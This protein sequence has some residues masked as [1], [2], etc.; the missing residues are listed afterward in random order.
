MCH[1]NGAYPVKF[2]EIKLN[3]NFWSGKQ[4]FFQ[5]NRAYTQK[6][7]DEYKV[8]EYARRIHNVP[9]AITNIKFKKILAVER[10]ETH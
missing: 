7:F 10:K 5:V 8:H 2:R 1:N 6:V 9:S 3:R 4:I